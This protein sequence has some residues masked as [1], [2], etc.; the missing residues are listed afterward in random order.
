VS[1]YADVA[2]TFDDRVYNSA[3]FVNIYKKGSNAPLDVDRY[4]YG[5]KKRSTST[6]GSGATPATQPG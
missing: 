2:V 4:A 1:L 5:K 6:T 3:T